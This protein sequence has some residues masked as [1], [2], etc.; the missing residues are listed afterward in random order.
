ML[1]RTL[2]QTVKV[3]HGVPRTLYKAVAE[4]LSFVYR[5]KKKRKA[6]E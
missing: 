5:L 1:A 4:V 6:L 3:G 2:F